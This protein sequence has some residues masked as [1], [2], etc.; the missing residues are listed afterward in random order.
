MYQELEPDCEPVLSIIL[1]HNLDMCSFVRGVTLYRP[2]PTDDWL[3]TRIDVADVCAHV[4]HHYVKHFFY[5][6]DLQVGNNPP[7]YTDA[8]VKNNLPSYID[9]NVLPLTSGAKSFISVILT[10]KGI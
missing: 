9:L 7:E 6:F 3:G 5:P 1:D 10:E 2:A 4:T 8:G